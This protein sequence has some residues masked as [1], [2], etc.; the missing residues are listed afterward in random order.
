[1]IIA[2]YPNFD[3]TNALNC[4]KEVC[5]ILH[6][7]DCRILIDKKYTDYLSEFK[8]IEFGD[9]NEFYKFC[10]M[11]V[12][13]GGD[14]TILKCSRIVASSNIPILGINSGRLGFLASVEADELSKLA[15][16][17]KG[18]YSTIK[19]M[20][21]EGTLI[22]KNNK[23]TVFTAL[24]DIVVAKGNLCKL[25]DFKVSINNQVVSSL[26][27]DGLIFS[28]PT[29]STAYS[30]SA[31][32]PII[33]PMIDCIEF[34]QICPFSLLARTM[35]FSPDNNIEI[36]YN[37]RNNSSVVISVDGI[38]EYEFSHEDKL[39]IT[40]SLLSVNF[41]DLKDGNF[42]NSVNTKLMQPLKNNMEV[43]KI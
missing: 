38:D 2:I 25:A 28:T 7:S 39:F 8:Y 18:N 20:M 36:I 6:N 11:I 12:V 9:F 43:N 34:T 30:L 24:N 10:D 5:S 16:I 26:R 4:T 19:R 40:K 35:L 42:Y 33:D 29:G 41:V 31:G 1:M 23:K 14:G 15:Y 27:A 21:L 22:D 3:K 13:I 17:V 32:G 37:S